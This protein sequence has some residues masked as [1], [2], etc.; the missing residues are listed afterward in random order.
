MTKLRQQFI[1]D[2]QLQGLSE[3]TQT[4]YV[5]SV[6]QLATYHR[7]S[8]AELNEDQVR[9]F[10]LY[11]IND[12]QISAD[13][14]SIK[15][16]GIKFFF[17]KTLRRDWPLFD[18]V[19]PK[20]VK[21]LPLVLSKEQVKALLGQIEVVK[22]RMCSMML[23]C[24]GLRISESIRV[25][26]SDIE[27]DRMAIRVN[28]G[29]GRK[30][31]YVPLPQRALE[32]LREY[33]RVERPEPYLFPS[34]QSP[35]G[36]VSHRTIR[37]HFKEAIKQVGLNA[38]VSPHTLRHSYATH[39]YE[40]GVPLPLIQRLLGHRNIKTTTIYTHLTPKIIQDVQASVNE[41]AEDL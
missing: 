14:L 22:M 13:T 2:L 33:W 20:R 37:R 41:L 15:L 34:R 36:H 31:R 28:Q 6:K 27:S 16:S 35:A 8:P 18:L 26:L 23:Y 24:C 40:R 11:L 7:R 21:K 19:K 4:A 38:K 3:G 9:D 32:L 39:L 1:Q 30:D 17:E 10:F 5:L 12:R 25:Q 29:K